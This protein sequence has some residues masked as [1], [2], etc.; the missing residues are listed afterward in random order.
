MKFGDKNS[1][2]PWL[3]ARSIFLPTLAWNLILARWLRRRRW[4]DTVTPQVFLGALPFARHARELAE[5]GVSA[6][7]NLCEEYAGPVSEYQKRNMEQLRL[8]TI[9]F[10]HPSLTDVLTGVHFIQ[11]IVDGGGKVY[12]HC[13]AGRGRS[14]TVVACWLIR[15]LGMTARQAQQKLLECRPHVNSRLH[16]R[17]VVIEFERLA[18]GDQPVAAR[19]SEAR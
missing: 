10:T 8:P 14:A 16:L 15:H 17:P 2:W 12:V 13:K 4:W 19:S 1:I 3:R 6:V 5:Q 9:D 11:R 7:V 18:A